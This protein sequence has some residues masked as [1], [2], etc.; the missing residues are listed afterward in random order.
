M[1]QES[2][3]SHDTTHRLCGRHWARRKHSTS[4]S[5]E[6]YHLLLL[7]KRGISC[8]ALDIL[9]IPSS[10][11]STGHFLRIASAYSHPWRRRYTNLLKL[12]QK[13][14][15]P[16]IT[17]DPCVD[18]VQEASLSKLDE[19]VSGTIDAVGGT[20]PRT[21]VL[22]STRS[23]NLFQSSLKWMRYSSR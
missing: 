17:P 20:I 1:I 16:D 3:Y 21:T 2:Y 6:Q 8:M 15:P 14:L 12:Q 11:Y 4:V 9:V 7:R 22:E 5:Y 23:V 19:V 13:H 18:T 10:V